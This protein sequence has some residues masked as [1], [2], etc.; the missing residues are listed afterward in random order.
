MAEIVSR[1]IHLVSRPVGMPK[2]SDFKMVETSVPDPGDGQV[3]VR[4]L[5]MSVD[6]YMRGRMDAAK[7][8]YVDPFE[9]GVVLDGRSVGRVIASN[10]A[11]Y[12]VGDHVVAMKGWREHFVAE[13]DILSKIDPSIA[14]IQTFLGTLG[15]PGL[16]AWVGMEEYGHPQAGETVFVSGAAGAVGSVACQIAKIKGCRVVGSAGTKEKLDWLI[17]DLGVDAVFNYREVQDLS[18]ELAKLCPD[19][20]DIYFENVGGDLFDAGLSR[21]NEHGRVLVCGS[22]ATYNDPGLDMGPR[23]LRQI[24]R[25]RLRIQGYVVV[26]HVDKRDR[27]MGDMTQW[28]GDGKMLWRETIVDGIENAPNA[29]LGL[30]TGENIGKMLVRLAKDSSA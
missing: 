19:G 2:L 17:D 15:M 12:Q 13:S 16:T 1:E 6:P 3:L 30:F 20:I 11:Q 21:M 25:R 7:G 8:S 9:L 14:P 23:N 24:T 22:I 18:A 27:F 5:F 26:D 28:I 4:N 29:F 10:S